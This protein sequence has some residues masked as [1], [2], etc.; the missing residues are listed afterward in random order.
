MPKILFIASHRPGRSPAQRFRFEQYLDYLKEKGFDYHFSYLLSEED[1]RYFYQRGNFFRKLFI[2]LKSGYKRWK[3]TLNANQYDIIFIQREAFMTGSVFFEKRF[4]QSKA[5]VVFDFDDA[6]WHHDVSDGNKNFSFL[7]NPSKTAKI[8]AMS[9][10]IFAGNQYLSDYAS[11]FNKNIVIVPTTIDTDDYVRL[12]KNVNEKIII[13]W[14]G[15]ITT[16]KHFEYALPFLKIIKDKYGDR[17]EIKVIGDGNYENKELNIQG[18]P[19]IKQDELKELSSFDIGI[20]PLPDDEW[21]KGKCGLKGL[22]YMALEIPTI[23]S[24]VGVNTDI[25]QDGEN[26]FLATETDE[27]VA[28]IERLINDAALRKS[29]GVKARQTVVDKYSVKSQRQ[30]YIRYFNQIALPTI[31]FIAAHRPNRSP[32]QRYRFEQYF[33]FLKQNGFNCEL[34][35]ILSEKDDRIFYGRGNVFRKLF[36]FLKAAYIR[37]KDIAR[38]KNADIIFIQREAFMTGSI[39]FEKQLRKTGK[40]IVFDFDDSLWLLDTSR[41]NKKWKWM[42]RSAKT[43][44]IIRMSDIVFAGNSFLAEYALRFNKSVKIIPTTIDTDVFQ[45]S[46]P[47]IE[48]EKICIGWSGSHTT[49]KHFEAALPVLKKIKEKYADRITFKVMGDPSYINNELNIKGIP[50]QSK[51]EVQEIESFDIGIMPLP[52]DEWVKGKCGLKGLS[53]MSLEVP[54]IMSNVGVNMEI[55]RDGKNGFLASNDNELYEKLELLINSYELRK[56]L[57]NEGRRTVI[58]RY[59]LSSQKH[60]YLNCFNQLISNK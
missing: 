4:S 9:D 53:Y 50:W 59:S 56:T 22:Q 18:L 10:L 33:S 15:S 21:T 16:I 49:I 19:W 14:S 36:I 40:P 34:S 27:W 55:I 26:G 2:F 31:L 45:R 1:D 30:N 6:I 37:W 52:N 28:K 8:I 48:K 57:G 47:Y 23:M 46:K 3:D 7:K 54:T 60:Q 20:M 11:Q 32:S 38:A 44:D 35:F 25:I 51:T 29:I 41:A 5:K 13:G 24:A 17:I 58:E 39:F 43:S 12:E 42:K